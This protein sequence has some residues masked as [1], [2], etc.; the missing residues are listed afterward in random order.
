M[1]TNICINNAV[2][3]TSH[4]LMQVENSDVID[5]RDISIRLPERYAYMLPEVLVYLEQHHSDMVRALCS[6]RK[7]LREKNTN[8]DSTHVLQCLEFQHETY[9]CGEAPIRCA[10]L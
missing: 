9:L 10:L 5:M 4:L 3:A 8:S 7:I 2:Y 6:A 1:S